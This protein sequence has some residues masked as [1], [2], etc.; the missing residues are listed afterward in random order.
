MSNEQEQEQPKKEI[1]ITVY[2]G[3]DKIENVEDLKVVLDFD[4]ETAEVNLKNAV[5]RSMV[6]AQ[7]NMILKHA[8]AELKQAMTTQPA[9]QRFYEGKK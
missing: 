7:E 6:L 4:G 9:P 3:E 1:G 8:I 2:L 5:I